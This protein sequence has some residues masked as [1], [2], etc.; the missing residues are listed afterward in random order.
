[1]TSD[2]W[3]TALRSAGEESVYLDLYVEPGASVSSVGPYDPWRQRIKVR[4]HEVASGGRA[5]EEMARV[6]GEA[7][8]VPARADRITRGAT[9]RRKTVVV[10]GLALQAASE[11]MAPVL[12]GE[13]GA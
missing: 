8:G 6:V 3:R 11:A 13:G 4:V 10:D 7:L 12:E 2:D 1:M 9:T 5:N